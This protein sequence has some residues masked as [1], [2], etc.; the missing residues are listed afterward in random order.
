MKT[1]LWAVVVLALEVLLICGAVALLGVWGP[2]LSTPVVVALLVGV[3]S[4]VV[5]LG[6]KNGF[7]HT[8]KRLVLAV[9]GCVILTYA[10]L[11]AISTLVQIPTAVVCDRR[12]P[13]TEVHITSTAAQ[14]RFVK[15]YIGTCVLYTHVSR[16]VPGVAGG[17]D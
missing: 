3:V 5:W 8:L 9:V 16:P 13:N 12:A 11:A 6:F 7:A 14:G 2:L 15:S 4:V 10:A 17:G 1:L